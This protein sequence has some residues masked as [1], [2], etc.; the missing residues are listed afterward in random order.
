MTAIKLFIEDDD[1]IETTL[2]IFLDENEIDGEE[3]AEIRTEVVLNRGVYIGGG[4]AA[5]AFSLHLA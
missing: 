1:V 5:V 3:A 2:E 4:G